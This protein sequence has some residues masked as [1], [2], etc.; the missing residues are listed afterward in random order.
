MAT[1]YG[2]HGHTGTSRAG[3]RAGRRRGGAIRVRAGAG[4]PVDAPDGPTRGPRRDRP[5][6]AGVD[7]GRAVRAGT[8]ATRPGSGNRRDAA[9]RPDAPGRRRAERDRES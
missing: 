7:R 2:G 8:A 6:T 9:G 4:R 1:G 5:V 3:A